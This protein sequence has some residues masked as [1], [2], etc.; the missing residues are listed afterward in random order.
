MHSRRAVQ[1]RPRPPVLPHAV[2]QSEP[3][4]A[5][6]DAPAWAPRMEQSRYWWP[7]SNA[8]AKA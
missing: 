5:L 1:E 8:G 6:A 3:E 7:R 2:Q 4:Q